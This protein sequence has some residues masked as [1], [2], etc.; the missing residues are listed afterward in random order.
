MY[1]NLL[2]CSHFADT[3][4]AVEEAGRLVGFVSG[5]VPPQKSDTVFVWQVVVDS[6]QRGRGLA[7][8][9]LHFLVDRP[10]CAGVNY[11]ETTITPD[12]DASWGLFRSFARERN[13]ELE[14]QIW[15]EKEAHFAGQHDSESLLRIGPF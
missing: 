2:Q 3:G 4:V 7:K 11:L 1:C 8:K 9:M 15:F 13:A 5:Y 14:H 6:S 12:N 10:A